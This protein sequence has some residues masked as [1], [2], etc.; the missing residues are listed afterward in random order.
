MQ[1]KKKK[2]RTWVGYLLVC[3]AFLVMLAVVIIP[4]CNSVLLSFQGE[5]GGLTWDNYL[6]FLTDDASI[7]NILFTL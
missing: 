5:D 4:I 3:P 1:E 7:R 2:S 6:Y